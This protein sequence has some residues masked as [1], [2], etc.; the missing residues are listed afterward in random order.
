MQERGYKK[1]INDPAFPRGQ[2]VD[3][4]GKPILP[5]G[6]MVIQEEKREGCC[7]GVCTHCGYCR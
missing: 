1:N 7:N 4:Q 6:K 3:I 5:K 2:A